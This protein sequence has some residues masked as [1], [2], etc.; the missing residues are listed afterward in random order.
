[1]NN[2]QKFN[3]SIACTLWR[4]ARERFRSTRGQVWL[5]CVQKDGTVVSRVGGGIVARAPVA[6][7]DGVIFYSCE[8]E[9]ISAAGAIQGQSRHP[10]LNLLPIPAY[11]YC[12]AR[13]YLLRPALVNAESKS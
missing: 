4:C 5:L 11:D 9:A 10:E 7:M 1:M 3:A 8:E 13:E 6:S 2:E 12:K